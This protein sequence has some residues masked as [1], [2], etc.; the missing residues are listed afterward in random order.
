MPSTV[1]DLGHAVRLQL[2]AELGAA[3]IH[4]HHADCDRQTGSPAAAE[5]V[6]ALEQHTRELWDALAN[7]QC[8]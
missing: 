7:A 8:L 6:A 2:W 5:R 3:E 1:S 4:A